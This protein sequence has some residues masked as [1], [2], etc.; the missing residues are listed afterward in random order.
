M[1][2]PGWIAMK[3]VLVPVRGGD[4]LSVTDTVKEDV[5]CAVGMPLRNPVVVFIFNPGGKVPDT[6]AQVKGAFPGLTV[7][8][9]E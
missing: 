1:V 8:G 6:S 5:P 3:N 4:E 2:K 7:N 9:W